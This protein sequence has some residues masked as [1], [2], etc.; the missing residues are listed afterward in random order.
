MPM[1]E[2]DLTSYQATVNTKTMNA[3][4]AECSCGWYCHSWDP[5]TCLQSWEQHYN[6]C[7]GAL[8]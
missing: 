5:E 6:T 3:W 4:Q 8:Q 7:Q 2:L 1:H